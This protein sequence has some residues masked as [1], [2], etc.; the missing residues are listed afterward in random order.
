LLRATETEPVSIYFSD[1]DKNGTMDMLPT[2]FF[3]DKEGSS[4]EFPYFGRVDVQ[5]ELIGVKRKF[6]KY[7]EYG[8][9]SIGMI[10][11][12]SITKAPVFR[13]N[14]RH[15]SY[16]ENLGGGRFKMTPLPV[17]TQMAPVFGMMAND[18]NNDGILDAMLIGNDYGTEILMG[19][20]DASIGS[21][22]FGNGKGTFVSVPPDQSG[23]C[24]NGDSKALVQL[25]NDS[26]N[27]MI[28]ASQNR[29]SLKCYE[30]RRASGF[31][32][33]QVPSLAMKVSFDRPNGK[34]VQ[35]V[36]H[37]N[38]FLSQSSR[39]ITIPTTANRMTIT[40]FGGRTEEIPL[41]P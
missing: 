10:L 8:V 38:G 30:V 39:R 5:K 2:V 32:T 7:A 40:Y 20:S 34:M 9:A 35:E 29:D 11:G 27:T 12:D 36:Y 28:V 1:F 17:E 21:V 16:I 18:F 13:V 37:G 41:R 14:Y 6:L 25:R 31:R 19:R 22:L 23:L 33:V 24:I 3:K 4:R 15:T 26:G